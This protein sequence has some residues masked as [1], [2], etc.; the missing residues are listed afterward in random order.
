MCEQ[1]GQS[2]LYYDE[3]V[4]MSFVG[5]AAI[6]L[7]LLVFFFKIITVLYVFYF[8]LLHV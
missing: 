6:H 4:C 1:K 7:L 3:V 5:A 2:S 8:I